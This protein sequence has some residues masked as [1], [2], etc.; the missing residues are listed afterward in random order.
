MEDKIRMLIIFIAI[1]AAFLLFVFGFRQLRRLQVKNSNIFIT[2]LL[3]ALAIFG[4]NSAGKGSLQNEDP[5]QANYFPGRIIPQRIIDLNKTTEWKEFKTFW[6]SIDRLEPGTGF[7]FG[8]AMPYLYTKDMI[9]DKLYHIEDSLKKQ[10]QVLNPGLQNLANK[11]LLDTL[12]VRLLREICLARVD[13]L[14]NG[15]ASLMTRMVPSPSII[16]TE[17]SIEMLEHRADLLLDLKKKGK[18]DT[19]EFNSALKN[20]QYEI[21][22]FSVFNLFE[23][24]FYTYSND[25]MGY[26][27]H[28]VNNDSINVIEATIT[29]FNNQYT[30]FM[31]KYD[32][33]K[34][35]ETDKVMHDR[36]II[37]KKDMDSLLAIY[38]GFQ[39][40]IADLVAND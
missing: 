34:S 33:S 7:N 18:I 38:P 32:P 22:R 4:C 19:T 6:K 36:Y 20:I 10:I 28:L 14:C 31:Q 40:L 9:Y 1:A 21:E 30:N 17:N 2:S 29:D 13:Y 5:G 39:Q 23:K 25:F 24:R 3:I 12:E 37:T 35:S 26:N 11:D 15:K 8:S 16:E 27:D